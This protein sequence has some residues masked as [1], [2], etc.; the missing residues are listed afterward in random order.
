MRK[1]IFLIES[2]AISYCP[3]CAKQLFYKDS[4][5]RI[6]LLEGRERRIYIIRRLTCSLC[7]K[8][9]RELPDCF[10]PYKHYSSEIISGTLDG[11]V[12]PEDDDSSDYPCEATMK[13]WKHWL[14]ANQ[15]RIDGYLKSIGYHLPGFSEELLKSGM[16]LLEELRRSNE[17]WLETI[18]RFIYNSGGFLVPA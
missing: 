18:L 7:E 14:I 16:S 1:K 13:K 15:L 17:R 2:S 11:Y 8:I 4:C 9:H 12:S 6:M 10:V 5:K 3:I